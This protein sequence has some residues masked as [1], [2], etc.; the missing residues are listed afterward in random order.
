MHSYLNQFISGES[1]GILCT[2]ASREKS[3]DTMNIWIFN[4]E[5]AVELKPTTMSFVD[6]FVN[7]TCME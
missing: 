7:L 3:F 5:E 6:C 2:F 1:R 4:A